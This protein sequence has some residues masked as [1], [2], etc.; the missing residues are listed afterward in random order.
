M[1]KIY[2]IEIWRKDSDGCPKEYFRDG[3]FWGTLE[4]SWKVGCF[5]FVQEFDSEEEFTKEILNIINNCGI[6]GKAWIKEVD[7]NY[8]PSIKL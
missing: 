7:D 4:T 2:C 8:N 6:I 1:K 3:S 5:D